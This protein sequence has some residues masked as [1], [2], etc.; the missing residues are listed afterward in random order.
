MDYYFCEELGSG[1]KKIFMFLF[2]LENQRNYF[3]EGFGEKER[4]DQK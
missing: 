4:E 1:C 3:L 2:G